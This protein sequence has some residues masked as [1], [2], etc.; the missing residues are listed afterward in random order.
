[1]VDNDKEISLL[2][3]LIARRLY[4]QLPIIA[5]NA[6]RV[7]DRVLQDA[8]VDPEAMRRPTTV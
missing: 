6:R 1:M 8:R 4:W 7:A 2:N 5:M 3:D